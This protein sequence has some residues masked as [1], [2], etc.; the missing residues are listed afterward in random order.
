MSVSSCQ[1]WP[2]ISDIDK[3]TDNLPVPSLVQPSYTYG[4]GGQ[5]K[6]WCI[7]INDGADS[8]GCITH[9]CF[10]DTDDGISGSLTGQAA[11]EGFK[12]LRGLTC[13]CQQSG[14]PVNFSSYSPGSAV[15]GFVE[16]VTTGTD[17]DSVYC[18][19]TSL[20]DKE[21]DVP[22]DTAMCFEGDSAEDDCNKYASQL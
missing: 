8:D 10:R 19:T 16:T 18:L 6:S 2:R 5:E 20:G 17:D 22:I 21:G 12:G 9:V 13:D 3:S 11:C 14:Y 1:K 7:S 4:V 15:P